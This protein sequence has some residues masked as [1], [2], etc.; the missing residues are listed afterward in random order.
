MRVVRL[1]LLGLLAFFVTII[2]LFPAAPLVE[3]IKPNIKPVE[4][5][6]VSGTLFSGQVSSVNYAD[7]LLPL[8]FQDVTWKFA[9]G[10]LLKAAAGANVTF[11]GYGGGGDG[12]VSRKI[13]GDIQVNDMTFNAE[14]KELEVLL[15]GP[16]AEFSGEITGHFD[17]V[18]L[19]NQILQSITG[20]I[21]WTDAIIVT[22]LYGP[23]I[24]ANF[25]ELDI[26]IVPGD[27]AT[28]T[29]TVTSN[30]GDLSVDG[31]VVVA[32]NGDYR[33]NMLFT[34]SANAPQQ[35]VQVLQQLTQ[36]AGGGLFKIEHEGNMNQGT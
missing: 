35:L 13:N 4:L 21:S 28:H 9:A 7:D 26:D 34:P 14:S 33:T 1:I 19:A 18:H 17:K 6:G 16:V 25:G 31:K 8:E 20:Q 36:P 15:P 27:S 5:A 22:R 10:A 32:A 3:K 12:Q 23:E 11:R 29:V 24:T 2:F 30:G